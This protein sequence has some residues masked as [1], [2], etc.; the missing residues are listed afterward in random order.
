[1]FTIYINESLN[2]KED[3]NNDIFNQ[4][5]TIGEPDGLTFNTLFQNYTA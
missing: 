3:P 2:V 1:M 4:T 5:Y